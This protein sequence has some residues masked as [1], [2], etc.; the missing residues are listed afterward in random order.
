MQPTAIRQLSVRLSVLFAAIVTVFLLIGGAAD[1]EG[2]PPATVEY[3]VHQGD[4]LWAIAGDHSLPG[5][6]IRHLIADIK[7]FSGMQSSALYP[8]QVLQ[9]P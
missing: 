3:V 4:T 6:D 9:I 8:G 5:E 1:A 2:P 7:E